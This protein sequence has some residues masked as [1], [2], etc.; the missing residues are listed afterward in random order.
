MK[1]YLLVAALPL[2]L[3]ACSSGADVPANTVADTTDTTPPT[4]ANAMPTAPDTSTTMTAATAVT[5]DA[6]G[7]SGVTGTAQVSPADSKTQVMV[8]L[9]GLEPGSAHAGHFHDGTCASPGKA[10]IALPDITAAE[11]GTGMATVAVDLPADSL[12]D[13]EHI[14]AYHQTTGADHGPTIVCGAVPAQ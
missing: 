12:M 11:D 4:T 8:M 6:V 5:L 3:A 10:V 9:N 13:G 2:V 14:I 1:R 7:G